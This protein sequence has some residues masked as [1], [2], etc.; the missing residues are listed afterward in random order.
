MNTAVS[1]AVIVCGILAFIGGD[2]ILSAEPV[3]GRG[4]WL[5]RHGL[6][7]AAVV[8]FL[9][10]LLAWILVGHTPTWRAGPTF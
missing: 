10:S 3:A 9:V 7:L 8:L 4:R 1:L 5:R 6:S 2:R